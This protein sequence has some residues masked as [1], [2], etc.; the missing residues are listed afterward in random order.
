[1]AV[2]STTSA[3]ATGHHDLLREEELPRPDDA[4]LAGRFAVVRGRLADDSLGVD[5]FEARR[6]RLDG[7]A[8]DVI[9]WQ[10][11][12]TQT[13]WRE[14]RPTCYRLLRRAM[15][16]AQILRVGSLDPLSRRI[17]RLLRHHGSPRASPRPR[18]GAAGSRW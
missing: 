11:T 7:G 5:F 18:L 1:M 3:S 13:T 14:T 10:P 6:G 9:F 12:E 15:I 8:L 17:V 16:C 2:R 4:E